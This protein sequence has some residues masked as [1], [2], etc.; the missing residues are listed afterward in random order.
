MP[1]G[2]PTVAPSRLM[3][4]RHWQSLGPRTEVCSGT[5]P[6]Q[7]PA[8]GAGALRRAVGKGRGS[9]RPRGT[10]CHRVRKAAT[11]TRHPSQLTGQPH[12]GPGACGPAGC[13]PPRARGCPV[14]P[15]MA[16]LGPPSGL[17]TGSEDGR[18]SND[19]TKSALGCNR[20]APPAHAH[21]TKGNARAYWPHL[22]RPV[23]PEARPRGTAN[24]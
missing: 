10:A 22:Q 24:P 14:G 9:W 5:L 6:T 19:K 8:L 1:A 18:R 16:S 7:P 13:Q 12:R 15:S 17:V 21:R 4:C 20:R 3:S 11:L 2:T 23:T